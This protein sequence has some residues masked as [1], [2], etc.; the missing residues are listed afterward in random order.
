[1]PEDV[2]QLP[3]LSLNSLFKDRGWG[4]TSRAVLPRRVVSS[5][6]LTV[7]RGDGFLGFVNSV[8]GD[9]MVSSRA[10][11]T[12]KAYLAWVEVFM[13]FVKKF[14]ITTVPSVGVWE[15][16]VNVLLTVVATLSQS[17]SAGTVGIAVSAVSAFMQ[18]NGMGSPYQSRLFCMVMKGMVRFLGAGKKKKPPVEAWHVAKLVKLAK[19]AK[20]T[21]LMHMQALAVL[22]V[23][24]ELFTRSQDFEEFDVCDFVQL[25]TGMRV[26]V[27]YAKNDQKG[28][29]RTAVLEMASDP[30]CCPVR[31]MR[32]YLASA[33]IRIQHGCTKVEGEPEKCRVCPPA[34]PSITR[35]QGKKDRPMPKARVTELLRV[36]FVELARVDPDCI[37]EEEARAFSSK[38]LRCGGVSESAAQAV[39]DGV[40][41]GHGGWLQRQSLVHYDLMRPG[42]QVDV[43]RALNSAVTK[44]L[45]L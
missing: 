26:Y 23:G 7:P 40:I 2:Q 33:G 24:W 27:R 10:D 17:Y 25:T 45:Q 22:L 12:W 41:Q 18:D 14:N 1:V 32:Q 5:K 44:W 35:F 38:S 42:E 29:T 3:Q 36:L 8:V 28:L 31:L 39:R 15:D 19:P 21:I 34:F 6:K 30:A 43:S 16:W 20:F 13:E 9:L 37:S 11:S 4:N